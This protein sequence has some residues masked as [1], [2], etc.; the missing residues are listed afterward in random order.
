[1]KN[2]LITG[3]TGLIGKHLAI[4]LLRQGYRVTLMSRSKLVSGK[5]ETAFWD[6]SHNVI[7]S[8]ALAEA[9]V[10]IHLAGANIGSRRWTSSRK[11][12][13]YQQQ[14]RHLPVII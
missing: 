12:V 7:D 6:P 14:G 1:M 13:N 10:I 4:E 8:K 9:D 3:G 2:I 11:K 5:T